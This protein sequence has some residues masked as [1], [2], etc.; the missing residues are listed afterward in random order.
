VAGRGERLERRLARHYDMVT[1]KRDHA[2]R[3]SAL[4]GHDTRQ[5][6]R[7]KVSAKASVTVNESLQPKGEQAVK[8]TPLADRVIVKRLEAETKTKGGIVLPDTAKEKP[9]RGKIKAVG[10]GKRLDSGELVKPSVKI[11]DEVIFSS[12]AGTE[13]TVE[14]EELLIMG[15][16]DILA[17]V[18][19]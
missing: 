10:E 11:G 9:K 15:Q 6:P 8:L 16:D 3:R 12:F 5:S 4:N 18:R 14:G 19:K 7:G 13:V 1:Q 17:V 2:T